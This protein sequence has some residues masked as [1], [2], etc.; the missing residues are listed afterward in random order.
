MA[1]R[2]WSVAAVALIS[3]LIAPSAATAEVSVAA[4]LSVLAAPVERIAAGGSV[5]EPG[6]TGMDLAE[7]DRIK[8]GADGV[9]LITFLN[10]STVTLLA[11]SEVTVRQATTGRGKSGIR[12]LIHAG[13]VWARVV[14]AAGSRSIL[15][16]ESNEYSA[17]AHDGLIGAEQ[18][19][20]GFVCWTRRG[21]LRLSDNR[22][23][24][25]EAVLLAGPRA[26]ARLGL[27]ATPEPFVA[28]SSVLEI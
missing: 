18:G 17:T 6:V 11:D 20:A 19:P 2:G 3:S 16:L 28:S 8:T 5:A 7:G 22:N 13:R 25:T 12:L 14:K 4:T 24:Q 1:R 10:G 26:R 23:G 15:T 9:A 27:Q 21:E